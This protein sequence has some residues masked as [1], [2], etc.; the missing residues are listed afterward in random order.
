MGFIILTVFVVGFLAGFLTS[1]W[2]KFSSSSD[3]MEVREVPTKSRFRGIERPDAPYVGDLALPNVRAPQGTDPITPFQAPPGGIRLVYFGYST[4]PDVCPTTLGLMR[5][6][7]KRLGADGKRVQFSMVALD[8]QRD[9]PDAISAFVGKFFPSGLALRT[10]DMATLDTVEQRFKV[11]AEKDAASAP[12][13]Y[14]ITHSSSVFAV[15]DQGR[16]L[17]QWSYGTPAKDIEADLHTLLK[18]QS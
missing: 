12:E 11:V 6:V 15:N 17:V 16:V 5:T 18:L 10:D 3:V 8:P 7:T 1:V 4:C 2:G 13:A 9:T 14:T